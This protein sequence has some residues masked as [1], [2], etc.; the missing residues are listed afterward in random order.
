MA[1]DRRRSSHGLPRLRSA[2]SHGAVCPDLGKVL[3]TPREVWTSVNVADWQR[4]EVSTL[5]DEKVVCKNVDTQGAQE[6]SLA[7]TPFGL[8]TYPTKGCGSFDR[9]MFIRPVMTEMRG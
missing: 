8:R 1:R 2:R 6:C 7:E 3:G 5:D 4:T 9:Q